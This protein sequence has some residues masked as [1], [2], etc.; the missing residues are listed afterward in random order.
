M[1]KG[2][3]DLGLAIAKHIVE[4]QGGRIW[5]E[6]RPGKGASPRVNPEGRR[7]TKRILVVENQADLQGLGL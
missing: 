4:M 6:S 1:A 3:T 2:G 7:M 5:V